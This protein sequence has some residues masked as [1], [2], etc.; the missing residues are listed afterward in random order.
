MNKREEL[1]QS[2]RRD[3]SGRDVYLPK[4][5]MTAHQNNALLHAGKAHQSH[6]LASIRLWCRKR[7]SALGLIAFGSD[8]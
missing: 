2:I 3:W 8:L 6:R 5:V 4:A 1:K 7:L